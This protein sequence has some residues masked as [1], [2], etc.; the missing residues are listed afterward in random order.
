VDN[1]Q[2][3]STSVPYLTP[4]THAQG[5]AWAA[6][7]AA[8]GHRGTQR[9]VEAGEVVPPQQVAQLLSIAAGE[10]AVVRRRVILLDDAPMELTDSYYPASIASGSAL[11][12][13]R[14]IRGGAVTLLAELGHVGQ[15][16]VEEVAARQP[17]QQECEA[18]SLDR[19]DPVLT[20]TR[21]IFDGEDRP[22]QVDLVATPA[23]SQ[24]FR[25]EMMIG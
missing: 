24:R 11:A 14:P 7:A 12:Q 5:D 10:N 13:P 18:F 16:V 6:E 17:T 1:Q 3:V 15:R 22:I 21:V 8:S 20:L 2:W 4:Q 9:I 19:C 25:Y 23:Q